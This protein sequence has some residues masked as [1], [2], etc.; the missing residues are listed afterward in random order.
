MATPATLTPVGYL[1]FENG[2]LYA[3]KSPGLTSQ[4]SLNQVAKLT[5]SKRLQLFSSWE[6][7]AYSSDTGDGSPPSQAG[8]FAFG[9]QAVV[10]EEAKV[11]PTVAL[12]YLRSLY[13]GNAPGLD[14]G[15]AFQTGI[16]LVSS[17]F[18]RVHMDLNGLVSEQTG[19]GIRRAQYGQAFSLART[20]GRYTVSAELWHF[21]QPFLRGNTVGNLWGLSYAVQPNLI[22]DAGFNRGLT[23]TSTQWETFAGFTYVLPR[24][25][26]KVRNNKCGRCGLRLICNSK[27]VLD[28]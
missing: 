12:S 14:M 1:Q 26:W 9:A 8:G 15:G 21:T 10:F 19:N 18:G 16:L 3:T 20:V 28:C 11:R 4:F 24:R 5:V 17:D 7:Y 6:P 2:G 23:S 25:L 22:F 13:G 27:A